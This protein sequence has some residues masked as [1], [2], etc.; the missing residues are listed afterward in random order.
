MADP[1]D[2]VEDAVAAVDALPSSVVTPSV[3]LEDA[4]ILGDAITPVLVALF[5][6]TAQ[7]SETVTDSRLFVLTDVGAIGETVIQT[8]ENASLVKDGALAQAFV[9]STYGDL[10]AD[11]GALAEAITQAGFMD[12]VREQAAL[13]STVLQTLV[14]IELVKA[15]LIGTDGLLQSV[16]EQL[17]T[18]T[19]I[20]N[21]TAIGFIDGTDLATDAGELTDEALPLAE[22]A[23]LVVTGATLAVVLTDHLDAF[24]LVREQVWGW[25]AVLDDANGMTWWTAPTDTLAMSRYRMPEFDAIAAVAGELTAVGAAGSFVRGGDTDNGAA[26]DAY[27][28]TGLHDFGSEFLKRVDHFYSGY[29]SGGS[30]QVDVGETS[31]GVEVVYSYTMPARA[32]TA[33]TQGRILL[34]RGLRSIYYRFTLRNSEGKS[35]AVTTANVDVDDTARKV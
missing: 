18:D 5:T 1:C 8:A 16:Y 6:D 34:G 22:L 30:M 21:D 28:R 13:S 14:A 9:F 33:P 7:A 3:P 10:I 20:G 15:S 32:A 11:T 17:T 35:L 31:T 29:T 27:V 26:I 2:I 19:A 23:N 25:A 12:Q 24:E 4:G